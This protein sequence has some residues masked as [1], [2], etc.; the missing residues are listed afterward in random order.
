[1][2]TMA[3][4]G[5]VFSVTDSMGIDRENISIPLGKEK[6]G[7]VRVLDNG[8]IEIILPVEPSTEEWSKTLMA[9]LESLGY[10]KEC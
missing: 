3:D 10:E 4:M 6:Q 2:I 8:E 5:F 1:M 9:C 7:N